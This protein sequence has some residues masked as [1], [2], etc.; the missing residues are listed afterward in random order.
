MALESETVFHSKWWLDILAPGAW[1]EVEVRQDGKILARFPFVVRRKFGL[2]MIMQP[3][4]T[5]WLGP[6]LDLSGQKAST[7]ASEEQRL[8][9]LLV[10][11]LPPH[12]LFVQCMAPERTNWLPFFWHGFSAIPCITQRVDLI[13]EDKMRADL[14]KGLRWEIG[15]AEKQLAIEHSDDMRVLSD[16]KRMNAAEKGI[17]LR[18]GDIALERIDE[19]CRVHGHRK[20]FVAM[21][22]KG[23]AT[24]ASYI[25][26]DGKTAYYLAGA[27]NP[28]FRNAGG[29]ALTIWE[30]MK[31]ALSSGCSIFDFEGSMIKGVE[32]FFRKFGGRQQ[33]YTK[34]V[35]MSRRFRFAASG[36]DMAA[37]LFDKN[38]SWPRPWRG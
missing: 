18:S 19:A 6:C 2:T 37:A 35:H 11:K 9:D 1:D 15:K 27:T 10:E 23:N 29:S 24:A 17:S 13:D 7:R 36:Y 22:G 3:A 12:D 5:P 20:I 38:S 14:Q 21:D 32:Q 33:Q 26:I 34:L 28:E 30:G 25:V 8:I 31:Y 4:L 16:L